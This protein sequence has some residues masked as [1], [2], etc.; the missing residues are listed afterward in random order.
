MGKKFADIKLGK[1][2]MPRMAR[3]RKQKRQEIVKKQNGGKNQTR[4][5]WKMSRN[6]TEDKG[7]SSEGPGGTDW[8]SRQGWT[9]IKKK[10]CWG[11]VYQTWLGHNVACLLIKVL[12]AH[13]SCRWSQKSSYWLKDSGRENSGWLREKLGEVKKRETDVS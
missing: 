9:P 2:V 3:V 10:E 12:C 8:K 4:W 11:A 6:T 7:L 1:Q 5:Q 13:R